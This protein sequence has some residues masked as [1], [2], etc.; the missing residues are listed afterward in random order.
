[1]RPVA[2]EQQIQARMIRLLAEKMPAE[3]QE[4]VLNMLVG[5]LTTDARGQN[6]L[7]TT[8]R[9]QAEGELHLPHSKAFEGVE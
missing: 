8:A 4:V 9:A 3:G 6:M 7:L 5:S 1:M 2:T